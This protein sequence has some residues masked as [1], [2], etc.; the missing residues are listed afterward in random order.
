[1]NRLKILAAVCVAT[2]AL[3]GCG[4]NVDELVVVPPVADPLASVPGSAQADAAGL[5]AYLEVLADN[6]S[7]DRDAMNIDAV[8]LARSDDTEPLA[9]K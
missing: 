2:L 6:T 4:D 1:M 7:E 9:L 3:T 5:L 8:V